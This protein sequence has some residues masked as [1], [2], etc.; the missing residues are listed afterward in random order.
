MTLEVTK[1]RRT[2]KDWNTSRT[3]IRD[4]E[5]LFDLLIK[6]SRYHARPYGFSMSWQTQM[7]QVKLLEYAV[8]LFVRLQ[9][10]NG[11]PEEQLTRNFSKGVQQELLS[12]VPSIA[13]G[14]LVLRTIQDNPQRITPLRIVFTEE[15]GQ[16]ANAYFFREFNQP[17][18]HLKDELALYRRSLIRLDIPEEFRSAKF[19]TAFGSFEFDGDAIHQ[20]KRFVVW[21]SNLRLIGLPVKIRQDTSPI[22]LSPKERHRVND[23]VWNFLSFLPPLG[24][25]TPQ[26][27]P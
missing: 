18:K 9:E 23:R 16:E 1:A 5:P 3:F 22:K 11:P 4:K 17:V 24:N 26:V 19:E 13:L 14:P 6:K 10:E 25:K 20:D 2:G 27:E 21:S 15:D 8:N 7:D 12:V